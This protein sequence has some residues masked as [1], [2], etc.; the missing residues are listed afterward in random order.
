MTGGAGEQEKHLLRLTAV[1]K[2]WKD[3]Q[4]FQSLSL[5]E[6]LYCYYRASAKTHLNYTLEDNSLANLPLT[7]TSYR[8][9]VY[10]L[11][12]TPSNFVHYKRYK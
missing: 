5:S 1:I 11:S 7:V 8:L 2:S 12:E 3:R 6:H 10:L 9:T 4:L